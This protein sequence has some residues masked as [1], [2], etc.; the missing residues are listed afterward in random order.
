MTTITRSAYRAPV[1][2]PGHRVTINIAARLISDNGAYGCAI[3][4]TGTELVVKRDE[5]KGYIDRAERLV[6]C[7]LDSVIVSHDGRVGY[8]VRAAGAELRVHECN[9]VEVLP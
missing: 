4:Y 9:I 3:D 5:Y 7:E 6:R 1:A 2:Q 8:V